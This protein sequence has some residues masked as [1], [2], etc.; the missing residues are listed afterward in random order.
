MPLIQS[1]CATTRL[2]E[3][4]LRVLNLRAEVGHNGNVDTAFLE[5]TAPDGVFLCS[6]F[7][8]IA[9]SAAH[10]PI[11]GLLNIYREYRRD[12]NYLLS[13]ELRIGRRPPAVMPQWSEE[14]PLALKKHNR[15]LLAEFGMREAMKRVFGRHTNGQT[16]VHQETSDMGR[17]VWAGRWAVDTGSVYAMSGGGS[18]LASTRW[19]P[20]EPALPPAVLP[21]TGST[22]S[23]VGE[24]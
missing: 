5:F 6:Y 3:R 24:H 19:I 23:P 21:P 12:I 2:E 8:A 10:R 20:A 9:M 14:D 7:T 16:S 15:R 18:G 1:S 13:Y 4:A 22:G 17:Q 11:D